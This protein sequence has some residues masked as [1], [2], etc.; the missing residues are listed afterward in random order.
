M[1][2]PW[3]CGLSSNA[4]AAV[5]AFLLSLRGSLAATQCSKWAACDNVVGGT[6]SRPILGGEQQHVRANGTCLYGHAGVGR[7]CA[8]GN[9]CGATLHTCTCVSHDQARSSLQTHSLLRLVAG[10]AL[11]AGGL[12]CLCVRCR[13]QWKKVRDRVT[14]LSA[15]ADTNHARRENQGGNFTAVVVD[16][17]APAPTH[18]GRAARAPVP[19]MREANQHRDVFDVAVTSF[20]TI[21][22][23][24]FVT[25]CGICI[26]VSSIDLKEAAYYNECSVGS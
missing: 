22:M 12:A 17:T 21:V 7:D 24:G 15:D 2:E 11:L 8:P 26:L 10:I 5:A 23:P 14:P 13:W 20:L 19:N 1:L 3:R 9:G 18:I 25:I 6:P 4:S 16:A